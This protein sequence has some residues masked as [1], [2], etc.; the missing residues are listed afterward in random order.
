[1]SLGGVIPAERAALRGGG[2][3]YPFLLPGEPAAVARLA[4]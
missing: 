4:R 2:K 1:M 3:Y